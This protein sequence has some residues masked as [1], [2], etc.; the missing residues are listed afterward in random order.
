MLVVALTGFY[1]VALAAISLAAPARASGFLMGFA[2]SAAAHY[3]ELTIRVVVGCAFVLVAPS[4]PF[5]TAFTVFGWVLVGTTVVLFLVPWRLHREF[6]VRAVPRALRH[7]PLVAVAS[8]L[9]GAFVIW[10]VAWSVIW[11]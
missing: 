7:L 1:F 9:L 10:S 4:V 8:L 3:A 11:S 6:A 5:S 2:S